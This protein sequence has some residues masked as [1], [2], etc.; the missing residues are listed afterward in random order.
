MPEICSVAAMIGAS[1]SGTSIL[2]Q[3]LPRL[4]FA[5]SSIY[6]NA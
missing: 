4:I 6:I 1:V 3:I 2:Q 5:K